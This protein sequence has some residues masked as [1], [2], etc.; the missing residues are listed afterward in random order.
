MIRYR[1]GDIVRIDETPCPCGR[2]FT[3]FAGGIIARADDMV[4]VRGVNIYPAA[5]ENLVRQHRTVGEFRVTITGGDGT[6]EVHIEIECEDRAD[7]GLHRR[8]GHFT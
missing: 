7:A 6:R 4:V 8:R 5:V 1:T 3:R 2:T